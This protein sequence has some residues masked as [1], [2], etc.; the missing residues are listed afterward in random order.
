[1]TESGRLYLLDYEMLEVGP[2]DLVLD[3]WQRMLI[4]PFTYANEDDH[5]KTVPQDYTHILAWLS[6][7]APELF[8]H[9]RVRER[10]NLYGIVYELDILMDYPMGDWPMERLEAYMDG[11]KWC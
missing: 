1:M 11:M 8:S 7:A 3:V 2:R 10:V 5:E 4:H 6:E 9:P